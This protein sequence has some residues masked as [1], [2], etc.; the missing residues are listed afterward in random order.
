[1]KHLNK[2]KNAFTLIELLVVIAI[3]AILAAML[4]PALARAKARAQR[5]NCTNNLKQIGLAFKT[6]AL[7]NGDR[8]PMNVPGSEGGPPLGNIG[9]LATATGPAA[10]PY[11][12]TA[13]AVMSNELSTPK[14]LVCPSDE[15]SAHT[16]FAM[17]TG[18][19]TT[20]TAS[21]NSDTANSALL[22]NQRISYALGRDATDNQP[23]MLLA[24]DRNIYGTFAGGAYPATDPGY[25]NKGA[26]SL[27]TNW[28][29]PGIPSWTDKI[30][31]KQGNA[32]ISDGSVQQLSPAKLRDQLKNSGDS[33]G[34]NGF[35]Q[36]NVLFFPNY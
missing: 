13:F 10:F 3:I 25:G 33:G 29:N 31:Q 9:T 5:I 15:R 26:I 34:Y 36:G 24:A 4:L 28:A 7:D 32:L 8:Y 30:H 6:W 11:M 20:A 1:M 18:N 21:P 19:F 17:G 35:P 2:K 14:V 22:C 27:G 12:Y 23:Q 16:N